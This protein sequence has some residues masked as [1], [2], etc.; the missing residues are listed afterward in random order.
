MTAALD[1]MKTI[2]WLCAGVLLFPAGACYAVN[3][4]L[5]GG[6]GLVVMRTA[7]TLDRGSV[8][9]STFAWLDTFAASGSDKRNSDAFLMP[10]FAYGL[11]D[12]LE[13]GLSTPLLYN[14]NASQ[15]DL[16]FVRS[17]A[18]YRFASLP[19]AGMSA[20]V[21]VYGGFDSSHKAVIASGQD[22]YGA[23]LNVS[24]PRLLAPLGAFHFALGYEKSD[25][26]RVDDAVR[27]TREIR[28]KLEFGVDVPVTAALTGS[29]EVLFSRAGPADDSLLLMPGVRYLAARHLTVIFG[30]CVGTPKHQAQPQF[31]VLGGISYLFGGRGA[32]AAGK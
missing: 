23:E 5:D 9:L 28:R 16:R 27:Y 21:T 17:Y 2:R 22:N 14:T 12:N 13:I 10:G 11:L 15:A 4:A 31:R 19:K 7:G 8:D 3:S 29:V 18:K 30:V 25:T 32:A 6:S 24:L 1:A 20:A 26:K